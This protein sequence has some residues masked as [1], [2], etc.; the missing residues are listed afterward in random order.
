MSNA[1]EPIDR[2]ASDQGAQA[3]RRS[4]QDATLAAMHEL[5]IALGAPAPGREEAWR[6][7]VLVALDILDRAISYE[8][9]NA[10][11]PDSLLSDLART[12]PRLRNRVRGL[13][14]QYAQV[15]RIVAALHHELSLPEPQPDFADIRRRIAWLLTALR[16]QRGRESDL[17]Y[18]AYYDSFNADIDDEAAP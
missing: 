4:D 2:T 3:Q 1:P 7:N 15:R 17:I 16:H 13:R 11:E 12:Q 18:E 14:T 5:E 6:D 9:R 8:Q 10:D